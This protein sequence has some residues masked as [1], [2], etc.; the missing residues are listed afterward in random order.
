[1]IIIASALVFHMKISAKRLVSYSR[2]TV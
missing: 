1:M 2:E